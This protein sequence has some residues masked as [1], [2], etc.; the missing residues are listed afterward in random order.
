MGLVK[1][2]CKKCGCDAKLDTCG[3]SKEEINEWLEKDNGGFQCFGNH[4]ELGKR[5]NYWNIDWSTEEDGE[6]MSEDEFVKD[7]KSKYNEVFDTI[8][9]ANNY[10]IKNFSYGVVLCEKNNEEFVFDFTHSPKGKR[11][12]YR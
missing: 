9:I 2:Y 10:E 11:Y 1:V 12:Y 3:K 4:V 6:A 7:L 8:E 5:S